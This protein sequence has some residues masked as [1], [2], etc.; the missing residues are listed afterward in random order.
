M[1]DF[2]PDKGRSD[3]TTADAVIHALD[4]IEDCKERKRW[5][6]PKYAVSGWT[7]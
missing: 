3:F 1:V 7:I 5:A 2:G 6:V 4:V